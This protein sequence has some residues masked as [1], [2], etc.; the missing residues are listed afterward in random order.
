MITHEEIL[1]RQERA[2]ADASAAGYDAL[3]VIGRS[4]YDR[5]GDLAYLTNHF[6]PFPATV[7]TEEHRGLGH[8][9]LLLPVTGEPT[10][11]TDPRKHR[12]DLVPIKDTRAT[13]NLMAMAID[14]LLERGLERGRIGLV[15]EDI[16]PTPMYRELR[17]RLPDA[18]LESEP[19]LI[20]AMRMIKSETEQAAMREAAN[21]ADI[22]LQA[23]ITT[24]QRRGVTERDVCAAGMYAAMQIGR[25]SS[26]ISGCTP[27]RGQRSARA[28]RRRLTAKSSAETWS[29]WTLLVPWR[30]T[31]SMSTALCR[32]DRPTRSDYG[33][34]KP[35][36]RRSRHRSTP[37][38]QGIGLRMF[39]ARPRQ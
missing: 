6:P 8:G 21:T 33:C 4:F 15:G 14:L 3:L 13:A 2:R 16:L 26:A 9:I 17:E 38:G 37:A 11:I 34:S 24:M 22:A 27:D 31:S 18:R 35:C 19:H 23:A 25:I 5:P 1:S 39:S 20:S 7:F 29:S 30:D 28:G 12:A 36:T 10:L 32:L